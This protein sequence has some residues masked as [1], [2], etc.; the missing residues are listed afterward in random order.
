LWPSPT[1]SRI[2]L[3][4]LPKRAATALLALALVLATAP[5]AE[6]GTVWF[7]GAINQGNHARPSTPWLS[8][9]GTL[10]VSRVHWSRWGGGVAVGRGTAEYH[11][12]T[13]QCG[14]AP[15]HHASV[16]IHLWDVR[17]CGGRDYYNPTVNRCGRFYT[18]L[19]EISPVLKK[20]G[21]AGSSHTLAIPK[22]PRPT[23]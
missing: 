20:Y 6:A 17:D 11:D 22:C 14:T 3:P 16:T 10:V 5:L 1:V 4:N 19:T 7:E 21:F 9:D 8:V 12:C 13:P 15:I 23:T 18:R 2:E